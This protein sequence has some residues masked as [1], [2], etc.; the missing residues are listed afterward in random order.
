ME[1]RN[2]ESKIKKEG[3]RET[4]RELRQC[5]TKK[6]EPNRKERGFCLSEQSKKRGW[7]TTQMWI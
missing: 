4:G 2:Q 6:Q 7:M 5:Y 3:V 1:G